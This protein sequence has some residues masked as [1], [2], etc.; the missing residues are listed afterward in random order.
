M[1]TARLPISR[2]R[3]VALATDLRPHTCRESPGDRA[4]SRSRA[5]RTRIGPKHLKDPNSPRARPTKVDRG[6]SDL[7]RDARG[8]ATQYPAG[9]LWARRHKSDRIYC[10]PAAIQPERQLPGVRRIQLA[11]VNQVAAGF[12][13]SPVIACP[14]SIIA[15]VTHKPFRKNTNSYAGSSVTMLLLVIIRGRPQNRHRSLRQTLVI[16]RAQ[17]IGETPFLNDT[18][19]PAV[20][21]LESRNQYRVVGKVEHGA[22]AVRK[23]ELTVTLCY[24]AHGATLG[25]AEPSGRRSLRS[26]AGSVSRIERPA[27][28]RARR[29][30]RSVGSGFRGSCRSL[31]GCTAPDSETPDCD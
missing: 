25:N 29:P 3:S 10:D 7:R 23:E 30:S 13:S 8:V 27:S 19:R 12:A 5:P 16:Q 31:W 4:H 15:R 1:R 20:P 11:E 17:Q 6:S 22:R 24:T 2:W 26:A 9:A 21:V 18:A 28:N 14:V